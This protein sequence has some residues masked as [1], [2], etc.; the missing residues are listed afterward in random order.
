MLRPGA[1]T[2]ICGFY[3][4]HQSSVLT[5]KQEI[6]YNCS[7]GRISPRKERDLLEY[8]LS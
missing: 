3:W 2:S 8:V 6:Q 7:Q 1:A 5:Q 4:K